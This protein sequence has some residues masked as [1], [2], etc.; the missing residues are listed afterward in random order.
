[1]PFLPISHEKK[2]SHAHIL[3]EKCPFSKN[4]AARMPTFCQKIIHSL[5]NTLL[6]S[7]L[8][9]FNEKT[10]DVMPIVVPKNLISVKTTLLYGQKKSIGCP[11]FKLDILCVARGGDLCGTYNQPIY[12][13]VYLR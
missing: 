4:H 9:N 2:C 13:Y 11:F 1:M 12:I 3:S 10:T 5:K 6:H 7:I 8:F